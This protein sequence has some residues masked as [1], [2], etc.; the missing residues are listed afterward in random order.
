MLTGRLGGKLRLGQF[1]GFAAHINLNGG[2]VGLLERDGITAAGRT[3]VRTIRFAYTN[4]FVSPVYTHSDHG[5]SS[6]GL[7]FC[8]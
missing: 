7:T 5:Y 3:N 4:C 6:L 1:A 2:Q 8:A